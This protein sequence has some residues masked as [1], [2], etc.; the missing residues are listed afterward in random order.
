MFQLFTYSKRPASWVLAVLVLGSMLIQCKRCPDCKPPVIDEKLYPVPWNS[1]TVQLGNNLTDK[2]LIDSLQKSAPTLKID[3]IAIRRCPCD[4]TLVNITLAGNFT[5]SGACSPACVRTGDT[6]T[7]G[8]LGLPF[9]SIVGIN[10]TFEPFENLKEGGNPSASQKEYPGRSLTLAEGAPPAKT[11]RIGVFDTGLD[12]ERYMPS[13]SAWKYPAQTC[14][15]PGILSP[16]PTQT[17]FTFIENTTSYADDNEFKHGSRVAYLLARQFEGSSVLP[18]II[19][20]KVLDKYN[21]G[22]TF[23]LLCALE[24]ARLNGVQVYNLSLGG[25]YGLPHPLL[26]TY[27]G[28]ILANPTNYIVVAIG[29]RTE[30]D[31]ATN[32]NVESMFPSFYPAGLASEFNRMLVVTTV[33]KPPMPTVEASKRQNYWPK[34]AWGV[35][36]DVMEQNTDRFGLDVDAITVMG[37]SFAAPIVAG[38]LARM[39]GERSGPPMTNLYNAMTPG[40]APATGQQVRGNRYLSSKP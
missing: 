28:R 1:A 8:D 9:G 20:F 36:A 2:Q 38:R 6:G 5:I 22:D 33:Q 18:K 16:T 4:S 21:R 35:R 14:T 31:T 23:G 27:I 29:N 26:K 13:G 10:Y 34:L 37:S 39:I 17:G 3:S 19:P 24:T 15:I 30:A 12:E 25:Y 7:T 40:T 32:H 11:V